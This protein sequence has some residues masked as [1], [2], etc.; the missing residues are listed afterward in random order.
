LIQ[1]VC[2]LITAVYITAQNDVN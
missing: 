2:T 1:T